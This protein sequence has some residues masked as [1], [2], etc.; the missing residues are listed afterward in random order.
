MWVYQCCS[1]LMVTTYSL[2]LFPV[3]SYKQEKERTC[4]LWRICLL[5]QC[6]GRK[7][8]LYRDFRHEHVRIVA[9]LG[10]L[11]RTAQSHNSRDSKTPITV[12][13][14]VFV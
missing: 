9:S 3:Y 6:K 5:Y 2:C 14:T 12:S 1:L 8:N 13:D 10:P 4:K 7:Q 11:P